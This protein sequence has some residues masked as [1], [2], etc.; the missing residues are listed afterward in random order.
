MTF[1][2]GHGGATGIVPLLPDVETRSGGAGATHM[3]PQRT[4]CLLS[5]PNVWCTPRFPVILEGANRRKLT[6]LRHFGHWWSNPHHYVKLLR[7]PCAARKT[8]NPCTANEACRPCA[9]GNPCNPCLAAGESRFE[10]R[11][12]RSGRPPADRA[13][14]HI[15]FPVL[16][17]RRHAMPRPPW[18]HRPRPTGPQHRKTIDEPPGGA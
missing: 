15:P 5:V 12:I 18:P 9:A 17:P 14:P 13:H 7:N 6:H 2:T 8:C 10:E 4:R 16:G 1:P 11:Q 3:R